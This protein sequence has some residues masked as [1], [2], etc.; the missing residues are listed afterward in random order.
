MPVN[1]TERA[2]SLRQS[3]GLAEDRIWA[4]LRAGRL[5]GHKFRRQ[6]PI[7]P[8]VV[9]F[10]CDRLRLVIE[11]DGDVHSRED[12]RLKDARRQEVIEGLGWAVMR[13]TNDEVLLEVE[14]LSEAVRGH[15]RAL[16]G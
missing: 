6:H 13:F 7:G 2:R 11:V 14:R 15:V 5:D 1:R 12:V 3:S 16:E 10:A 9:D 8:Y 4:R